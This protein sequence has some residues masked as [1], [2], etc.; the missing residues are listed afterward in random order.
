MLKGSGSA[1]A[2]LKGDSNEL[3]LQ[4]YQTLSK[5]GLILLITV[6]NAYYMQHLL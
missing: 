2:L 5:S 1:I 3:D 4:T 6:V